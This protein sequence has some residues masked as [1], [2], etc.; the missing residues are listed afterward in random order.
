MATVIGSL[1]SIVIL[2]LI[3]VGFVAALTAS[4][5]QEVTVKSNTILQLKLESYNF[6]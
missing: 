4:A 6:V 3:A 5:D 2:V 1:L